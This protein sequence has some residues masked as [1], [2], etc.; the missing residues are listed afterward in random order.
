M[1][2][3]DV[4]RL[5]Y[6]VPDVQHMLGVSRAVVYEGLHAGIIPCLKLGRRYVIPR[7]AFHEW[8]ETSPWAKRLTRESEPKL[9]LATSRDSAEQRTLSQL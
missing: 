4:E 7:K 6:T 2:E 3:A 9:R 8:L 5:V 1:G